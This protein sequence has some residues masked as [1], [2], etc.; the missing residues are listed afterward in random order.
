VGG[1]RIRLDKD[2]LKCEYCEMPLTEHN[3][4]T[5]KIGGK[6]HYFCCE[7]C[8]E[9][10]RRSLVEGFSD[11]RLGAAGFAALIKANQLGFK[12]TIIGYGPISGTWHLSYG[13]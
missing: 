12:H 8:A 10:T 3:V 5:K 4:Y 11:H 2:V 1:L 7:H 6:T 9:P 13:G